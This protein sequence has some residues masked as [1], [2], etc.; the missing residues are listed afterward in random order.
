[1]VGSLLTKMQNSVGVSG[2]SL[3]DETLVLVIP[4]MGWGHAHAH[5][6]NAPLL[7]GGN[8]TVNTNG[9]QLNF[10]GV[11][12]DNLYAMLLEAFG[13]GDKKF[14]KTGMRFGDFGDQVLSGVLA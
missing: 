9:R 1:M 3:L 2:K 11:P 13:M 4:G 10:T 5:L 8:G 7:I 6:D 12:L 14:G